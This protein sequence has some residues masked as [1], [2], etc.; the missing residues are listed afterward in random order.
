[1]EKNNEKNPKRK[2]RT[3]FFAYPSSPVINDRNL[4]IVKAAKQ[5]N[6]LFENSPFYST[7]HYEH[8]WFQ[9]RPLK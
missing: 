1:M 6:G 5:S 2:R 7:L 8:F 4:A 3:R 9:K